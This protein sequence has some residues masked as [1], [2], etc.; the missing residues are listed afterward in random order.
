MPNIFSISNS[1]I[2]TAKRRLETTSHNISNA[3]T[4]GYS[5]QRVTSEASRPVQIGS[6]NHGTGVDVKSVERAHNQLL[7]KKLNSSL[8][9]EKYH[10]EMDKQLGEVESI[11]NE[12]DSDGFNKLLNKFFNTFRELSNSPENQTLRD[13]VK[14]SAVDIKNEFKRIST[15]LN[16]VQSGINAKVQ[17]MGQDLNNIITQL[18]QY[19]LTINELEASGGIANDIRDKRD[20]L[21]S[22]LAEHFEIK[23]YEDNKGQ[24]I[25]HA[26]NLGTLVAGTEVNPL[27]VK[28]VNPEGNASGEGYVEI[29][30][31]DNT[32]R[33]VSKKIKFGKLGAISEMRDGALK[34]ITEKM[35]YLAYSLAKATNA[36]H[37]KGYIHKNLP[38]DDFGN[39]IITPVMGKVT[40]IDFFKEPTSLVG[41]AANLSLSEEVE[42][43][44]SYIV[45]ALQA[46]KPG[47]NRISVAIS[48]LQ[49]QKV[50][51]DEMSTFEEEYLGMT[52]GIGLQIATSKVE[53]EQAEG[54]LNQFKTMKKRES[55]VSIDEEAANM[56]K[57]QQQFE[58]SAKVMRVADEMFDEILKLKT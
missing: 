5:R 58:A 37:R 23:T 6:N 44:S 55:G 7:E 27:E 17:A 39:P 30:F 49:H 45:T 34:Q 2:K 32:L 14:Q 42:K 22:R 54:I 25:V 35:D 24:F 9:K 28:R 50:L 38:E 20:L 46:N 21:V 36:I 48:Q 33:P 16:E 18:G 43:D 41:A 47:D 51:A 31:R 13:M 56:V 19:N 26:N 29:L 11:F 52:G 3:N 4:E 8:S 10:A 15:S 40:G 53:Q 57:Y 12:L 1:G